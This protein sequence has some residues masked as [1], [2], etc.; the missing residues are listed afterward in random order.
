MMLMSIKPIWLDTQ[1]TQTAL[2][3]VADPG[4]PRRGALT[5]YFETIIGE[6]CM[7]MKEIGNKEGAR[8]SSAPFDQPLNMI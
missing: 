1:R 4:F 7:K 2:T 8:V 5:Y 3:L 6:N